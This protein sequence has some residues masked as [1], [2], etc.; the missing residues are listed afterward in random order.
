M[1]TQQ[2]I[3]A[4]YEEIYNNG[5]MVGKTLIEIHNAACESVMN[6]AVKNNDQQTVNEAFAAKM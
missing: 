1:T 2:Q 6:S 4:K 3:K 5:S